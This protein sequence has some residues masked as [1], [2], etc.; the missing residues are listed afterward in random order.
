MNEKNNIVGKTFNKL[1]VISKSNPHRRNGGRYWR[2]QCECGKIK[3][4]REDAFIRGTTK[5][6][7]CYNLEVKSNL[8]KS[9]YH[10]MGGH[11]LYG[12]WKKMRSRITN[13]NNAHYHN[14]G[15]RGLEMDDSWRES[16]RPFIEW[17]ENNG[18][19]EGCNLTIDRIDNDY[20]Y[21]PDNCRFTDRT[22]QNINQRIQQNNTS[23]YRGVHLNKKSGNW[24]ARISVNKKRIALGS[25]PTIE[26]AA[27]ARQ[28]AEIKYFGRV[29]DIDKNV[30][31]DEDIL[32][33]EKE[34]I[35]NPLLTDFPH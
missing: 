18:W 11:P 17:A 27:R 30:L 21:F 35:E 3:D 33:A 9:S 12:V 1:T 34:K 5:S 22:E 32:L 24:V 6:C 14:Y 28:M 10:G 15:G 4:I 23:G 26:E 19:Y 20:G 13:K 31:T 29:L 8:H 7:G 2:C 16:P 25:Y